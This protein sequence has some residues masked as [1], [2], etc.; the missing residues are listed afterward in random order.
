[1]TTP[2]NQPSIK[3]ISQDGEEYFEVDANLPETNYQAY[4]D[5]Q[6]EE[7]K[8]PTIRKP[9]PGYAEG[10]V[11]RQVGEGV[12]TGTLGGFPHDT[13]FTATE[14]GFYTS[15]KNLL[16]QIHLDWYEEKTGFPMPEEHKQHFLSIPGALTR[17]LLDYYEKRDIKDVTLVENG[18]A[19]C[20]SNG[21]I[22]QYR[23]PSPYLGRKY[24]SIEEVKETVNK[25]KC[26]VKVRPCLIKK[27]K[28]P[29]NRKQKNILVI[30]EGV[31]KACAISAIGYDALHISGVTTWN[32]Y[33]SKNYINSI[34]I[35]Y[36]EI[37]I[38]F[39]IDS[40]SNNNVQRELKKISKTYKAK[41][42]DWSEKYPDCKGFDDLVKFVT[43]DDK[44]TL[45]NFIEEAKDSY[46]PYFC[47]NN[48]D[49]YDVMVDASKSDFPS[50]YFDGTYWIYEGDT[51]SGSESR[52]MLS[53]VVRKCYTFTAKSGNKN[54]WA[55][56]LKPSIAYLQDALAKDK[57]DS[58]LY[59]K[60]GY[61]SKGQFFPT[62]EADVRANNWEYN[63]DLDAPQEI[64]NFLDKCH[65]KGHQEFRYW[66]RS[67]LDDSI[68]YGAIVGFMGRS[69]SGKSVSLKIAQKMLR[70][71]D[72]KNTAMRDLDKIER[73]AGLGKPRLIF[74]S[75]CQSLPQ[76]MGMFYSVS[77]GDDISL[78]NLFETSFH[79]RNFN[80]RLAFG[81]VNLP[82]VNHAIDGFD[83][84]FRAIKCQTYKGISD[85]VSEIMNLLD[86]SD[87]I[88]RLANW[89]LSADYDKTKAYMSVS[90]TGLE[91]HVY[92][93]SIK[94]NVI[95][96]YLDKILLPTPSENPL[97]IE[98]VYSGFVIH[99]Q[100]NGRTPVTM[101]KFVNMLDS[102]NVPVN[103]A[104]TTLLSD[105]TILTRP[106]QVAVKVD[107]RA[108]C[109]INE[110]TG[111][112]SRIHNNYFEA[113]EII[114]NYPKPEE[115]PPVIE[116]IFDKESQVVTQVIEEGATIVVNPTITAITNIKP[117]TPLKFSTKNNSPY[118]SS[119]IE[120]LAVKSNSNHRSYKK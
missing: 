36:D 12:I 96:Q 38:A 91:N 23:S 50:L 40:H 87:Y 107:D 5:N 82:N 88:E 14:K 114:A 119:D 4:Y 51:I 104:S 31:T 103:Q 47:P 59:L 81:C 19:F 53:S 62:E 33:L 22:F 25:D 84:R 94:A 93:D 112:F 42:A 89:A 9:T 17:Y 1:M 86:N 34:L 55:T 13:R 111:S 95:Y 18:L 26:K 115:L 72:V 48:D 29:G 24:L 120:H 49:P 77:D 20:H 76:D 108:I 75:D 46:D 35:N 80:A 57:D 101:E 2:T 110:G 58:T 65:I 41:I 118:P 15:S 27:L 56:Q 99:S 68:H 109:L 79:Q 16:K 78:R 70:K 102:L 105:G 116:I 113:R 83:R 52:M 44:I 37:V 69:G 8:S 74:Q 45:R 117:W 85:D 10:N 28:Q 71:L 100:R 67:I 21:V 43:L 64:I 66:L 39:D 61:F 90:N 54:K 7:L 6:Q 3:V 63:T 106:S 11:F 73:L 97:S 32:T 60:N 98:E 92:N 30:T